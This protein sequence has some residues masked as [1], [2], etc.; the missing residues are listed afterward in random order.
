LFWASNSIESSVPATL[1]ITVEDLV[2]VPAPCS[3][4]RAKAHGEFVSGVGGCS[5]TSAGISGVPDVG[6]ESRLIEVSTAYDPVAQTA[7]TCA[8]ADDPSSASTLRLLSDPDD[9]YSVANAEGGVGTTV[10]VTDARDRAV[11]VPP[12]HGICVV[13]LMS[14]PRNGTDAAHASPQDPVDDAAQGD[15]LTV[16]VRFDLTQVLP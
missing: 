14:W 11:V 1:S 15:S 3:V 16:A 12:R 13:V 9:L 6:V 10:P 5:I 7:A 4:S 8:G 2:D